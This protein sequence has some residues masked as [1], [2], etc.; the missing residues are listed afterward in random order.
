MTLFCCA[1]GIYMLDSNVGAICTANYA[2]KA[3]NGIKGTAF[4]LL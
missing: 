1:R 2:R 3:V 4:M